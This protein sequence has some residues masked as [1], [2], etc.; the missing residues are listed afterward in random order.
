MRGEGE[1]FSSGLRSLGFKGVY[2]AEWEGGVK[3]DDNG[4]YPL[5]SVDFKNVSRD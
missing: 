5:N 3:D 1:I 4:D 2:W